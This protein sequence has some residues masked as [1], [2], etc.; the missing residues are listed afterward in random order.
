LDERFQ[1]Y[2]FDRSGK[3][4]LERDLLV[5]FQIGSRLVRLAPRCAAAHPSKKTF[6]DVAEVAHIAELRRV[7]TAPGK[8]TTPLPAGVTRATAAKPAHRIRRAEAV[9]LR[10]LVFIRQHL[11]RLVDLLE[12]CLIAT[13]LVRMM[14]VR[15]FAIRFFNLFFRSGL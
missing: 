12:F 2:G 11:I 10:A 7:K 15:K 9:V 5:H 8:S 3:R 14:L 4:F 13:G 1:V 6:E